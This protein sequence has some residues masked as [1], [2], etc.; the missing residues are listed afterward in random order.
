[1]KSDNLDSIKKFEDRFRKGKE[2]RERVKGIKARRNTL[3]LMP[4]PKPY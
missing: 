3:L 2:L 1:M 4:E